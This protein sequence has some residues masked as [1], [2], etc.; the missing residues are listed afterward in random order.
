MTE[1]Y[2]TAAQLLALNALRA[3]HKQA[4]AA[5]RHRVEMIRLCQDLGVPAP[6]IAETITEERA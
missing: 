1:P 6:A 4:V 2:I 3:A 5:D